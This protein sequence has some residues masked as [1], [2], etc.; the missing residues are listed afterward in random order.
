MIDELEKLI[1]SKDVR[2]QCE[3]E[4][5]NFDLREQAT[6]VWNNSALLV[7]ERLALF[8]QILEQVKK[9][10]NFSDV[11][12]KVEYY[13]EK[14]N[15][16]FFSHNHP[17]LINLEFALPGEN[18]PIYKVLKGVHLNQKSMFIIQN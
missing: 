1:P 4:G 16:Q 10:S 15:K 14:E 3:K 11:S 8:E 13:Y 12:C 17:L 5:R 6:L 9:D 18:E 7:D 2:K